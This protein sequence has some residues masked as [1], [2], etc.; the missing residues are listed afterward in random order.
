M[1]E[2]KEVIS[3]KSQTFKPKSLFKASKIDDEDD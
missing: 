2:K 1:L 3:A